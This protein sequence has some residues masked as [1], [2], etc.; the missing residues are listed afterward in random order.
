MN[1][2]DTAGEPTSSERLAKRVFTFS[3]AL[4]VLAGVFVYGGVAERRDLPPV[5]QFRA[6]YRT[7]AAVGNNDVT[8]HP[9]R[10]H[11]QPTRGQGS[12]LTV[13]D[14]PEDDGAL[15]LMAGFFDDENQ[16]RIV[17]RDGSVVRTWSLDLQE[18]F[19]DRR[20]CDA[21][22]PLG[23]DT[24]GALATP[25]GDVLFNY[26]YCGTVKL[27]QCGQV[28][29][30]IARTTHHSVVPAEAG[31]YWVLGRNRWS[32]GEQPDWVPAVF[33]PE[34]G[35]LMEDT[36]L[37]VS[38]DGEVV[39]EISIPEVMQE[40]GLEALLTASPNTYPFDAIDGIELVHANKVAEL[41][42]AL[43]DAYPLFDAGDLVISLRGRNLVLVIDPDDHRVKWHQT[44]PWLRQ[45]DP[46]FGPDGKISIF[47][48]NVYGPAYVD[49]RV[50]LTT[51]F[52]TNI[53]HVDPA[54]GET[55]VAY[56]EAPGQEMLSVIR[57]KHQLLDDGGMLITEFDAGRVLQVDAA[58]RTVWEYVNAFDDEFVG[59]ITDA[60]VYPSDYFDAEWGTCDT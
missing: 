40:G 39:E 11:L 34:D 41:P 56:G 42:S 30:S 35:V 46:H 44:G 19:P 22:S 10:H 12:G 48:N 47:N 20:A 32:V 5:P 26:E 16:I 18:H 25:Q 49:G 13:N 15:I 33:E 28:L 53:L 59:E 1:R 58:G 6:A 37:R 17:R 24:H 29:W 3:L 8:N 9:R 31:G 57:G 27:D 55:E 4:V 21:R 45:H 36:I 52:T 54:T 23:V 50:D 38:E 51:P 60:L 43:A 14:L 7:L 2:R